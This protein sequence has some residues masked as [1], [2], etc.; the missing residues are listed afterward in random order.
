[1]GDKAGLHTARAP[2][3]TD[4]GNLTLGEWHRPRQGRA[5]LDN[6]PDTHHLQGWLAMVG[7]NSTHS[8]HSRHSSSASNNSAPADDAGNHTAHT[9]PDRSSAEPTLKKQRRSPPPAHRV[10][11][12]SQA[13]AAAAAAA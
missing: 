2:M 3:H 1:M 6:T 5:L 10:T 7:N 4:T 8:T 9:T 12:E 13:T 11:A